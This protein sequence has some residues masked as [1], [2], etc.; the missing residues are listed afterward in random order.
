MTHN[1]DFDLEQNKKDIKQILSDEIIK[2]YFYQ[3][4]S[5]EQSLKY[6]PTLDKAIEIL[7]DDTLYKSILTVKK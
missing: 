7:H 4:G 6:D 3:A 2:R 5:V 1:V